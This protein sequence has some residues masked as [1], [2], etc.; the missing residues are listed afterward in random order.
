MTRLRRAWIPAFGLGEN[1]GCFFAVI[2]P[3]A[4]QSITPHN[5]N[6]ASSNSTLAL[7]LNTQRIQLVAVFRKK[8][9]G[10]FAGAFQGH[11]RAQ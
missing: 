8:A 3:T 7:H 2:I 6:K 11:F 4:K 9:C 1:D 10:D 5:E